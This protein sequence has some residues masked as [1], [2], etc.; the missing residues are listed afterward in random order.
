MNSF[1]KRALELACENVE[2]GGIPLELS[3]SQLE[4]SSPKA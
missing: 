4:T 3:L 1:S 2:E